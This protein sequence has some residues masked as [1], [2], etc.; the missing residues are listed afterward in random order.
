MNH[1]FRAIGLLFLSASFVYAAPG[2]E[3]SGTVKG[4]DGLGYGDEAEE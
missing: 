1:F 2:G 3:L 4:P